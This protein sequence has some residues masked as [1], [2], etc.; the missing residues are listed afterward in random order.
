MIEN[1]I[2]HRFLPTI[3][4]KRYMFN[5][6]LD[7]VILDNVIFDNVIIDNV[8]FDNVI[9]VTSRVTPEFSPLPLQ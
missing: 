5:V 6:I 3:R 2:E 1:Y 8:I 7:N 4:R 9:F